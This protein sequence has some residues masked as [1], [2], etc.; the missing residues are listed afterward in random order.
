MAFL[1]FPKIELALNV[2][3]I[4]HRV[5]IDRILKKTRYIS[6]WV[7]YF[8]GAMKTYQFRGTGTTGQSGSLDVMYRGQGPG[9][10]M[11]WLEQKLFWVFGFK[12]FIMLIE[13]QKRVGFS[14]ILRKNQ[15]IYTFY[16]A[17]LT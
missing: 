13:M 12:S 10:T 9:G 14:K 8:K 1:T 6:Q 2:S 17:V 5:D 15:K 11:I 16:V 7:G 4:S 3:R